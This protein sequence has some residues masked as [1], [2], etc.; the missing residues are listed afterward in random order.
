MMD[1]RIKKNPGV[2][3]ESRAADDRKRDAPETNFA[4]SEERR[5][6]FRSEWLQEALPTP[7]EIPGFHLCW[8]IGRAHV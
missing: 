5:K 6:M 7:P 8:Q 1:D 3:R 2:G 4:F